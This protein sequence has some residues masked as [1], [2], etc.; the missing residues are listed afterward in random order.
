MKIKKWTQRGGVPL[1]PA[2]GVIIIKRQI[3]YKLGVD[4]H[5]KAQL[6]HIPGRTVVILH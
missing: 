6:H 2:T 4:H 1:K 3:P 5:K